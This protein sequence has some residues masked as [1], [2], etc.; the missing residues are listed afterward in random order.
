M[1][2]QNYEIQKDAFAHTFSIVAR[3][4]ATGEM[5]VGVQSHWFSVGSVVAWGRSGVGVVAT[6][7]FVNPAYG[8]RGLDLMAAGYTASEALDSLVALDDGKDYRQVAFLD[9][10]GRTAAHTG[11]KCVE[12]AS[13]INDTNFSVQAN[14]M[15]NDAVVPAMEKAFKDHADLP[16]AERVVKVLQAAQEAGGDI[17]GKQSAALLVVGPTK[18]ENSWEDKKIDLRVDDHAEPLEELDRLLKVARAYEHM[19]RG[20]LAMEEEDVEEALEQY[21]LAMEMF[22]DN[23][24][25][26]YWTAVALANSDRLEEAIPL[27]EGIFA[28]DENWREMTR[29]LPASGLLNVSE[30]ELEEIVN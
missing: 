28:E 30:K 29:R 8:P 16:L 22:P 24:E 7:S 17:R 4:T 26:K 14:M 1:K 3:D 11:E 2:A 21:G 23:L 20:D 10:E 6:Q 27:F 18:V 12:A 19:N 9:T 15:L 25:M 13:H 5:A